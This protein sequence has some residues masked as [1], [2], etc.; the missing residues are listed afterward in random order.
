MV[1]LVFLITFLQ[2]GALFF[3]GRYVQNGAGGNIVNTAQQSMKWIAGFVAGFSA[4]GAV[5]SFLGGIALLRRN[6]KNGSNEVE[7]VRV[8]NVVKEEVVQI[9][10]TEAKKIEEQ[11][12][13]KKEE[14]KV[15]KKAEDSKDTVDPELFLPDEKKLM[16][17]LDEHGGAMTQRDISRESG[18]SKVKV[19]RVLKS[20]E[21]KK[22]V[23]KYDFGMTKRIR[24]EKRLK[25]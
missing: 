10:S 1:F 4:I 8:V 5:V 2:D 23:T 19:H 12:V 20:L 24:L 11:K 25:A 18:L 3:F 6:T 16:K 14:E 22:V 9:P 13:E 15:E 17:L 7:T 21:A